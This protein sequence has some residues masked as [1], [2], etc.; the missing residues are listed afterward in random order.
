MFAANNNECSTGTC[1]HKYCIKMTLHD[2]NM[3]LIWKNSI[4][5]NVDNPYMLQLGTRFFYEKGLCA[6]LERLPV[7]RPFVTKWGL[8]SFTCQVMPPLANGAFEVHC[9]FKNR[10]MMNEFVKMNGGYG[11]QVHM[12][13]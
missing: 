5:R 6:A 10:H 2:A 3:Q 9:L 8:D 1:G 12:A 11:T 13:A 4:E 7:Y